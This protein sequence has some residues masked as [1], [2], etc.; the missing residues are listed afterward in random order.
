M[1]LFVCKNLR[2]INGIYSSMKS[3]YKLK[4]N[5]ETKFFLKTINAVSIEIYEVWTQIWDMDTIRH[6][7]RDTTKPKKVGHRQR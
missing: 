2:H 6:K 3:L 5:E 7:H 4:K 1:S